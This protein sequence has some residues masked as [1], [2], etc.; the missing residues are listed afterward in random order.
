MGIGMKLNRFKTEYSFEKWFN[1]NKDK[2]LFTEINMRLAYD[3]VEIC[4][5]TDK[6]RT[7]GI[8][9]YI[10][11]DADNMYI[12]TFEIQEKY[13]GRGYGKIM[14]DML[15]REAKP[16]CVLLDFCEGDD[17]SRLFWKSMGFHRRRKY[18]MTDTEMY[19]DIKRKERY[20]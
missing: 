7:V 14:F 19:K 9:V 3:P 10:Q 6:N 16:K 18:N 2:F 1:K 13:R 11:F 17:E 15:M 12:V 4:R 8:V 20:E 5:L